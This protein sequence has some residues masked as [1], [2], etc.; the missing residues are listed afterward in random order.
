MTGALRFTVPQP[1]CFGP[2]ALSELPRV[3]TALGAARPLV[4]TDPGIRACGIL[5]RALETLGQG[6]V[7]TAVFDAVSPNPREDD[8]L[9]ALGRYRESGCDALVALGGGSAI[10][11]AKGVALLAVHEG[12][13]TDYDVLAGGMTRIVNDL[14]PLVAIPT[15]AGTGSEVSR[16][17][18]IVTQRG[19]IV[20][21]T[22]AASPRMVPKQAIL[23]PELTLSLPPGL[24]AASGMDAL[25]HC[26]EEYVSPR[27]H[28]T[29]AAIAIAGVRR[30]AADLPRVWREPDNVEARGEMLMSAMMGGI[31]FEK[32]LGVAHSLAHAIGALH[33]VHHGILNATLL[34][35]VLEFNRAHLEPGIAI[36][37]AIA[38]QLEAKND[39]AAAD[40]LVGWLQELNGEF[41]IPAR[42][43]DLGVPEEDRAETVARALDDHCHRTNPRK[44]GAEEI[45]ELWEHAW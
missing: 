12:S 16:G 3:L 37:M 33:N 45:A 15:T 14:P 5:D 25:S 30:L 32:G 34:P 1:I 27:Y 28:P 19:G 6:H 38:T 43:R 4:V 31:G 2:G 11:A 10:D 20:R 13:F 21:K 24:T 17:A 35:V 44:C 39:T 22:I 36:E 7:R 26:I 41:G 29:V 42:L 23:D 18:L 9:M 8:V 40:R